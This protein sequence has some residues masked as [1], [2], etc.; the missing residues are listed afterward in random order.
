MGLIRKQDIDELIYYV[1]F[2]PLTNAFSF[3]EIQKGLQ[4]ETGLPSLF[5][6]KDKSKILSMVFSEWYEDEEGNI[7]GIFR[8]FEFS[9]YTEAEKTDIENLLN[10]FNSEDYKIASIKRPNS[11]DDLIMFNEFAFSELPDEIKQRIDKYKKLK[12]G[13][14]IKKEDL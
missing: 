11:T 12:D 14:R 6:D 13:N 8:E 2:C 3:G 1:A 4:V 10:D 9:V 5:T 7:A